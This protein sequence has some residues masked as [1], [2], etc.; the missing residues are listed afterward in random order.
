MGKKITKIKDETDLGISEV[1]GTND[2]AKRK[3][4]LTIFLFLMPILLLAYTSDFITKIALF[5]YEAVLLENYI[6]D[7]YRLKEI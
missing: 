4:V 3:P 5:F 1:D 6:M 2:Q 7:R